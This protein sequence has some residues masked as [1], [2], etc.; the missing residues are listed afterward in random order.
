MKVSSE[1]WEWIS[2]VLVEG[3]V[4]IDFHHLYLY[5][6]YYGNINFKTRDFFM[7]YTALKQSCK[8]FTWNFIKM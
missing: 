5:S 2:V 3:R 6:K 8:A 7:C 4:A 1:P